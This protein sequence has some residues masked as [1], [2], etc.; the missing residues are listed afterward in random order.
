M[1]LKN[2]VSGK[3]PEKLISGTW[4]LKDDDFSRYGEGGE[5][6]IV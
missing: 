6:L 1:T 3:M 4:N 5:E 2:F